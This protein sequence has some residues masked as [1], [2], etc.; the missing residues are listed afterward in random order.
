MTE[1]ELK[2]ALR[3]SHLHKLQ[4]RLRAAVETGPGVTT[5]LTST[6]F[7]TPD[8]K[9]KKTDLVLRVGKAGRRYVQTVKCKRR[10]AASRAGSS[11]GGTRASAPRQAA[12]GRARPPV[13]CHRHILVTAAV[14]QI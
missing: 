5:R 8:L 1:T 10:R 6:Y 9:L 13:L 2:V 11:F 14:A 3:R 7:D 12:T 4:R